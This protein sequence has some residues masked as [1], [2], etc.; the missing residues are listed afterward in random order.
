MDVANSQIM[1]EKAESPDLPGD[2]EERDTSEYT[3]P[4]GFAEAGMPSEDQ[5]QATRMMGPPIGKPPLQLKPL[6]KYER[7]GLY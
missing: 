6:K 1:E 2:G 4:S 7:I 3:H 5:S